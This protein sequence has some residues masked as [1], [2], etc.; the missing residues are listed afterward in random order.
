[1]HF[2]EK[3]EE[4]AYKIGNGLIPC[5]TLKDFIKNKKTSNFEFEPL[6]KGNYTSSNLND[7]LPKY[8]SDSTEP[9]IG[10]ILHKAFSI[11]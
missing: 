10:N 3:L 4:Q 1:M 11:P 2:Q 9:N 7:L 6:T 8:I 5:Q